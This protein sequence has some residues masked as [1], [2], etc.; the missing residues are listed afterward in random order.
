ME[1]AAKKKRSK[2]MKRAKVMK[3]LVCVF[4]G[5]SCKELFYSEN[6]KMLPT[7][8]KM[9]PGCE[10]EVFDIEPYKTLWECK[11]KKKW[12]KLLTASNSYWLRKRGRGAI[13]VICTTTGKVFASA[14]E[15][16]R[17]LGIPVMTIYQ[18]LNKRFAAR[19]MRFEYYFNDEDK[20]MPE[21][22]E[23]EGE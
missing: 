2:S 22:D 3:F 23:D 10:I 13:K 19:G 20:T 12:K 21:E 17:Q 14:L 4:V 11:Q 5:G 7:L 18:A 15:C 16:S 9:Y 6:L 8:S 1:V